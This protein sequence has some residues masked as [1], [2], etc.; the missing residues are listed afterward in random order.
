MAEHCRLRSFVNHGLKLAITITSL[1]RLRFVTGLTGLLGGG[2][3]VTVTQARN[4]G[5][6]AQAAINGVRSIRISQLTALA[7]VATFDAPERFHRSRDVGA[8]LGLVPQRF[9]SGEIDYVCSISKCGD[10]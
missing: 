8:Y 5:L 9:L 6:E 3:F 7:F 2:T 10:R 4:R 1:R